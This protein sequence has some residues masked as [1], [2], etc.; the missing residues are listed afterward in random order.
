MQSFVGFLYTTGIMYR[1]ERLK[2]VTFF[3]FLS[4]HLAKARVE[5]V[6]M[7]SLISTIPGWMDVTPVAQDDGPNP[8]VA[9]NYPDGCKFSFNPMNNHLFVS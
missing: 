2:V 4:A 7:A 6:D 3:I 9:I 5:V 1:S 8:V